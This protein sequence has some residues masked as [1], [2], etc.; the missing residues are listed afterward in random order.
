MVSIYFLLPVV[1]VLTKTPSSNL[2]T[3]FS[4]T[5]GGGFSTLCDGTASASEVETEI[6]ILRSDLGIDKDDIISVASY[7]NKNA[8]YTPYTKITGLEIDN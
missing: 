4:F 8:N 7:G 5:L 6:R 3:E 1:R 2:A